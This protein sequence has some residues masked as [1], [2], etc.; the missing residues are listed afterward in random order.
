MK[1]H[2]PL[3]GTLLAGLLLANGASATELVYTPVNPS[4]GGSPLN[5][6]WLLG[7]AQA[8]NDHKDPDAIDRSALSGS[9][10]DRFTSQLESRLLSQMLSNIEQGKEG[11][12]TTDDFIIHIVNDDLGNLTVNI[13]DKLTGEISEI[14]VDGYSD[15]R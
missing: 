15:Y 11:V 7:N 1:R 12:L 10:L 14:I 5:G 4:F 6:A 8:Q 3:A 9:A 2:I 13:T